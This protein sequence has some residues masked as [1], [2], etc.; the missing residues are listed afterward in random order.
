[1]VY[2]DYELVEEEKYEELE[3]K[4]TMREIQVMKKQTGENE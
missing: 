4:Y 3:K 2:E 1:M